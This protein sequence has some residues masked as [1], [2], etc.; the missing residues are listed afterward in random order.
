MHFISASIIRFV[1]PHQPGWVECEFSDV[2]G[3]RHT[4]TDKVPIFTVEMLDAESTY[5]VPDKIPCEAL[6][7]FDDEMEQKMVRVTTPCNIE[8]ADGLSESRI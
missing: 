6:E 3:H 7:R 4:L 8:S 1:D 5:P 2:A